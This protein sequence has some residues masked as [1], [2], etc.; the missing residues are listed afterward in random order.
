MEYRNLGSSGLKVSAVGLGTNQFGG[1]V[2]AAEVNKIISAA[3]VIGLIIAALKYGS[4]SGLGFNKDRRGM[5]RMTSD[6]KIPRKSAKRQL[7]KIPNVARG[8]FKK[9][10]ER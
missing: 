5:S 1:K 4:Y 2:D 8:P 6:L 10:G 9:K 3:I 7:R